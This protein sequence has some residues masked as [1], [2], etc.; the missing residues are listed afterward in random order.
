MNLIKKICNLL[1]SRQVDLFAIFCD[2]NDSYLINISQ[3][4]AV[5]LCNDLYDYIG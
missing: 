3:Y 2:I 5:K 4:N 1:P